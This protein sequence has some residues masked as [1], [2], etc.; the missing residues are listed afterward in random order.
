MR[1]VRPL[2]ELTASARRYKDIG[3]HGE[4]GEYRSV[5]EDLALN[6]GD[7]IE[8]LWKTMV[9]MEKEIEASFLQIRKDAATRERIA[10]ELEISETMVYMSLP[11]SRTVYDLEDKTSNARRCDRWRGKAARRSKE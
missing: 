2:D 6:T 3:D 9:D 8:E 10:T 4:G 1:V 5:F 11:Y 7:E